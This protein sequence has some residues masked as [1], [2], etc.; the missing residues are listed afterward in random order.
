VQAGRLADVLRAG[1]VT[2][3]LEF[4]PPR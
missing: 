2:G 4:S 3:Q 1:A